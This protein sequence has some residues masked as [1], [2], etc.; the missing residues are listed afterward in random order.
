MGAVLGRGRWV[1]AAGARRALTLV[2]RS[3][4]NDYEEAMARSKG[5]ELPEERRIKIAKDDHHLI[6]HLR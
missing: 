6:A 5:E 2:L 3:Q 1:R 4:T